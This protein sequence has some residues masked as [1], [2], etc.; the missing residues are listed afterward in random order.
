[1][2]VVVGHQF[3]PPEDKIIGPPPKEPFQLMLNNVYHYAGKHLTGNMIR[4]FV[5]IMMGIEMVNEYCG[6]IF[7]R[8]A[9]DAGILSVYAN[10]DPRIAQLLP[11]LTIEEPL[12]DEVL[13]RIDKALQ[14]LKHFL[15]HQAEAA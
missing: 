1:M 11:P 8:T 4:P 5:D 12:V 15:T 10:N 7:S 9:Y 6:P 2:A 14:Q 3:R 13:K